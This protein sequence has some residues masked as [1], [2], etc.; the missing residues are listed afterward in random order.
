MHKAW[1]NFAK[2]GNP[3]IE[4]QEAWL[5]FD[6]NNEKVI[7]FN[8]MG[9]VVKVDPLAIRLEQITSLAE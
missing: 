9:A 8:A 7:E 1:V 2:V 6:P 4:G 5:K 3:S